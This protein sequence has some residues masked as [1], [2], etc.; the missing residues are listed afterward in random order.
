M[1]ARIRQKA[2]NLA[3]SEWVQG[4]PTKIDKEIDR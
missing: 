1:P 4:R 3:V 2:P